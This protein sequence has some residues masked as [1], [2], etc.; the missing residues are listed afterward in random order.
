MLSKE[1]RVRTP[2]IYF[3]Q[4]LNSERLSFNTGVGWYVPQAEVI[5]FQQH[6][7]HDIF[8]STWLVGWLCRRAVPGVCTPCVGVPYNIISGKRRVQNQDETREEKWELNTVSCR[9]LLFRNSGSWSYAALAFLPHSPVGYE[10]IKRNTSLY[11]PSLLLSAYCC[12][13]SSIT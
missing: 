13:L 11:I 12:Q 3:F 2:H 10:L 6:T 9:W 8:F 1:R 4:T 5:Y 7:C